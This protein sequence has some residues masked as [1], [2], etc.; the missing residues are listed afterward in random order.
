M[1]SH[2]TERK[3]PRLCKGCLGPFIMSI[4]GNTARASSFW[5]NPGSYSAQQRRGPGFLCSRV[6]SW[7]G[8]EKF[9]PQ[10][11]SRLACLL[12]YSFEVQGGGLYKL[13][14]Q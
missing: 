13:D 2:S 4:M 10:A 14:L 8:S 7:K 11:V 6:E 9:H 12:S 5:T 1:W 3:A